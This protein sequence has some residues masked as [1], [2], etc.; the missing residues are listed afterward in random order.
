MAPCPQRSN[1]W[2]K[3]HEVS[4]LWSK[5]VKEGDTWL[6]EVCRTPY[7]LVKNQ[8]GGLVLQHPARGEVLGVLEQAAVAKLSERVVPARYSWEQSVTKVTYGLIPSASLEPGA[9]LVRVD[10]GLGYSRRGSGSWEPWKGS[11]Q[12]VAG[13]QGADGAAGRIGSWDDALLILREGDVVYVRPSGDGPNYAL[14][15]R[16]GQLQSQDWIS[17]KIA[18]AKSDPVFYVAKG[19]A[20]WGHVPAEWVGKVVTTMAMGARRMSG[21]SMI[22]A[23]A[24]DQTGELISIES[25]VLNLGW[26]GR[27]RHDVTVREVLWVRLEADKQVRRLEGAEAQA[28]QDLRA[29][30]DILR[31]RAQAAVAAPHFSFILDD[32]LLRRV[33]EI[34]EES[35]ERLATMPQAAEYSWGDSLMNWVAAA[36]AVLMEYEQAESAAIELRRRQEAGEILVRFGGHVRRAAT[37]NADYWVVRPDGTLRDPDAVNVGGRKASN[38]HWQLV[39]PEEAALEWSKPDTAANHDCRVKKTPVGGVTPEQLAAVGA[40]EEELGA[41]KG[42]F[43]LDPE[44]KQAEELRMAAI[45]EACKSSRVLRQAA[46]KQGRLFAELAEGLQ[47]QELIGH[48]G[49]AVGYIDGLIGRRGR[50][51]FFCEKREAELVELLPAADGALEVLVYEKYGHENLNLRWRPVGEAGVPDPE[52][53]GRQAERGAYYASTPAESVAPVAPAAPKASP[54]ATTF[55][56]VDKKYVRCGACGGNVRRAQLVEAAPGPPRGAGGK[57]RQEQAARPTI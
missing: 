22:S 35:E 51:G 3:A 24:D 26:D 10:T 56:A 2:G 47:Y 43:G 27:D 46:A 38:K 1:Y 15:V 45:R 4:F 18:D 30:A 55:S 41:P 48:S 37:G 6:C 23:Y 21:G 17:W 5:E 57:N 8:R 49:Q 50:P 9:F 19:T 33:R 29:E 14:F 16:V 52:V 32:D 36:K 11:P 25:F 28:R 44:A 40:I 31:A 39:A 12:F 7:E 34:A 13:G 53:L 54:K 20:P 42:A